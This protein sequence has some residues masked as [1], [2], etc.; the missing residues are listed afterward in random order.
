MIKRTLLI[1]LL[2]LPLAMLAQEKKMSGKKLNILTL[3]DSNGTFPYSWPVQ[4]QQALPNAQVFNISKSGRTIGFLN[5]NDSTLNALLVIDENLRKAAAF[6]QNRPF[7]FVVLELGTNDA[8]AVFAS[9]QNEVPENLNRLINKIKHSPYPTINKAR[10]I[11]IAPPP[12][13]EKALA[14]EKYANGDQ[15]VKAMNDSFKK[16]ALQNNCLFVSGYR[17]PGLDINSMTADGLHLDA[18]GSRRLIEPVVALM[19]K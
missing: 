10:I 12:Y 1:T 11:I 18:T 3:G 2:L 6:T 5:L 19:I 4:L 16:I 17:T 14:T 7:D 15:R 13:G 9:R 8:K